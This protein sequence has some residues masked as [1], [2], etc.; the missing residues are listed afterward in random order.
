MALKL[1]P[2][3]AC[4]LGLSLLQLKNGII[5]NLLEHVVVVFANRHFLVLLFLL[6]VV[7]HLQKHLLLIRGA[8]AIVKAFVLPLRFDFLVGVEIDLVLELARFSPVLVGGVELNHNF[9]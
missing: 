2:Q 7:Q 8:N 1:N 5:Q 6:Q 3:V 4:S 9:F